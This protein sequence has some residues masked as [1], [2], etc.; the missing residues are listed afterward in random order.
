MIVTFGITK[1]NITSSLSINV[2]LE[3]I[4]LSTNFSFNTILTSVVSTQMLYFNLLNLDS[5]SSIT[6][7][8]V[9]STKLT[10]NSKNLSI[11]VNPD[12]ISDSLGNK[13]IDNTSIPN[14][15]IFSQFTAE[16]LLITLCIVAVLIIV[17][18]I[19]VFISVIVCLSF[20][21]YGR[22]WSVTGTM[23]K[24][25]LQDDAISLSTN[26]PDTYELMNR[27]GEPTNDKLTI[28]DDSA[29]T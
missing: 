1:G 29:Y 2:T 17:I 3:L 18:V 8:T 28:N 13:T 7:D 4:V 14:Y 16:S 24:F 27:L 22:Q 10:L 6:N 23:N 21:R 26:D 19:I 20:F 9:F 12:I 25:F 11:T 15:F 5:V